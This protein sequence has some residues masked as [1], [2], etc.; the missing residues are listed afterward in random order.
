MIPGAAGLRSAAF[1]EAIPGRRSYKRR[2]IS[3]LRG[4]D[5]FE[6][7]TYT[8]APSSSMLEISVHRHL[9]NSPA[10]TFH[11]SRLICHPA[12][13]IFLGIGTAARIYSSSF[14]VRNIGLRRQRYLFVENLA[15]LALERGENATDNI[16]S[17]R[18]VDET[19]KL[20]TIC[21]LLR[22]Q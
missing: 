6:S 15:I 13:K 21:T 20:V 18:D 16:P 17:A 4:A 14:L 5:E 11:H 19:T 22:Y 8:Y 10:R 12:T 1:Q 9:L 3:I 2:Y 7:R